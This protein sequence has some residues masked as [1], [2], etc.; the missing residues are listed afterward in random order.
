M[1]NSR[2]K[3]LV[4][5]ALLL[6]NIVFLA[7]IVIDAVT[8]AQSERQA[9]ENIC[10]VLR[11]GGIAIDSSSIISD[12]RLVAMRTARGDE[13]EASIAYA[14]LGPTDMTVQG[15]I[16]QYESVGRGV[17]EFYSG[18]DF[19]IRVDSGA[20]L[21]S[22]GNV[23][24]VQQLL[25]DMKL[26]TSELIHTELAEGDTITV[27]SSY[28][29]ASIFNCT[30]DFVFSG[31][32]LVSV[33][34]RYVTDFEPIEDSTI[35]SNVGAA[36]LGFLSAVMDDERGDV[37]CTRIDSVKSGYHHHVVG[38][39]GGEITPVW[40]IATDMGSFYVFKATGDILPVV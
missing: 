13:A 20:V 30:I 25:R 14:V 2:I 5:A 26:E 33:K 11:A 40:L 1:G 12:N 19:E 39:L 22:S 35:K 34:G 3:T 15:V 31:D 8:E 6:V 32:V 9:N 7:V 27:V 17:A 23:R 16:H 36:L 37:V 4:I 10:T 24:T 38:A 29:G 28:R 18:G 21:N